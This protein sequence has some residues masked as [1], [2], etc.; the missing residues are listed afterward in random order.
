MI[1]PVIGWEVG[2]TRVYTFYGVEVRATCTKEEGC[3]RWEL[4]GSAFGITKEDETYE[5]W[6]IEGTAELLAAELALKVLKSGDA[7][8]CEVRR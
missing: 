8:L 4:T 2:E 5:A 3:R 7:V 6:Q 1:A